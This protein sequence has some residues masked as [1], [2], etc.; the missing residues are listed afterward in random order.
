MKNVYI[1]E[2]TT[3]KVIANVP[4]ELT[5]TNYTPSK[6]E[7]EA[8]AWEAAVDDG[9]VDRYRVSD[10]AFKI[11]DAATSGTHSPPAR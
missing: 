8:A 10:Y 9:W 7:Y 4:I 11:E 5:A 2:K 6:Q 3:G 1:I